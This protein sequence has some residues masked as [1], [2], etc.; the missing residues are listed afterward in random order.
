MLTML[1]SISFQ[2]AVKCNLRERI[3]ESMPSSDSTGQLW[4]KTTDSKVTCLTDKHVEDKK[5]LEEYMLDTS[6]E[7]SSL[8]EELLE[9]LESSVKA[10]L[11]PIPQDIEHSETDIEQC[12]A[13][14]PEYIT[15]RFKSPVKP[16]V[17]KS[18]LQQ[19]KSPGLYHVAVQTQ[20]PSKTDANTS[21]DSLA[22]MAE[23]DNLLDGVEWSP[24]ISCPDNLH[25]SR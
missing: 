19:S 6:L 9:C 2:N 11:V 13:D 8:N 23:F 1:A 18:P 20:T 3:D 14:V 10:N 17:H 12:P 15:E 24:M 25:S 4:Q 7:N 21:I 5:I 22:D 16:V